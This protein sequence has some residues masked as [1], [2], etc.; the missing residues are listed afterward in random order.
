MTFTID[1]DNGITAYANAQEANQADA[2][3]TPIEM[4]DDWSAGFSR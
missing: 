4:A 1:A 2:V 3:H